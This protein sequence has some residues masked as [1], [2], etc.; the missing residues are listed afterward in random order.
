MFCVKRAAYLYPTHHI[1][2]VVCLAFKKKKAWISQLQKA[3]YLEFWAPRCKLFP[4]GR[5]DKMMRPKNDSFHHKVL[6][7]L[8][9]GRCLRRMRGLILFKWKY[10]LPKSCVYVKNGV[11]KICVIVCTHSHCSTLTAVG[12]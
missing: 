5:R 11:G 9:A 1:I 2:D 7:C 8:L 4:L 6:R 3:P 10:V 12:L